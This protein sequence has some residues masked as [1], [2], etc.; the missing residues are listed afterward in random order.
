[1]NILHVALASLGGF[2]AYFVLGGLM[3]VALP[4]L[5]VEFQ[6]YPNVYRDHDG[7]MSHM[8][9]GMAAILLSMVVL[10]VLYAMLAPGSGGLLAGLISG[11]RFGALIGVFAVGSFVLH[12]YANLKIGLKLTAVSAI[13]YM[14]EWTAAGIAIGLIYRPLPH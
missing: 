9:V 7:Q 14:V 12:N 1:M 3:F 8:P 10:A 4:S 11:A 2:L 5:K 6:K 13:A